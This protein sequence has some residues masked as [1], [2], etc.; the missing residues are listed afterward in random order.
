MI[1]LDPNNPRAGEVYRSLCEHADLS[2]LP[3]TPVLGGDTPVW[4]D[5]EA[6]VAAE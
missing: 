2:A 1:L 6:A 5:S 3:L 4:T